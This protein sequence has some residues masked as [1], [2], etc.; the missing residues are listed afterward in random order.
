[1]QCGIKNSFALAHHFSASLAYGADGNQRFAK[2]NTT[3][4]N[5]GTKK[6]ANTVAENIP[7]NTP[8]PIAFWLPEPAPVLNTKGVTPSI[9]ASEVIMIGRKI[10]RASCREREEV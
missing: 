7:P 4:K 9:N 5:T 2:R 6:I 10:G 1:M 8:V 3:T